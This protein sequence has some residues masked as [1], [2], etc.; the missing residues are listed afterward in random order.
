M[1]AIS[2]KQL[3][4]L[5]HP[6]LRFSPGRWHGHIVTVEKTDTGRVNGV[7]T[8]ELT[9]DDGSVCVSEIFDSAKK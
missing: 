5:F 1:L 7:A 4:L 6:I 2:E 3:T 9:V 8:A